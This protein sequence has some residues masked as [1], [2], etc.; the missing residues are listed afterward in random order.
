VLAIDIGNTRTTLGLVTAGKV[1]RVAHLPSTRLS[2]AR[3]ERAIRTALGPARSR[4][5]PCAAAMCSVVPARAAQW[6]RAVRNVMEVA[7]L[8]VSAVA[9]P[10]MP[11]RY[12]DPREAGP[13]R[14]ANAIAARAFYGAPA[15]VVDFGTATNFECVSAD[16]AFLGGVIAPGVATAAEALYARAARIGRVTLRRQTRTLGR[17]TEEAVRAGIMHGAAAMVDG[18]IVRLAKEMKA[19][20]KVIATGGVA[21]LM[22][23]EC[24]RLEQ[25]DEHLTLKGIARVWEEYAE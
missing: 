13:D 8:E 3:I 18:L 6:R 10:G 19:R 25:L 17:S 12:R 24:E 15:I 5:T 7:P 23:K 14:L 2:Q 21:R 1:R 22:M 9:V 4:R 16:G 20:P 11:I